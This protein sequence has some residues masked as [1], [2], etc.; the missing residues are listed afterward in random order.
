MFTNVRDGLDCDRVLQNRS[1]SY[2]CVFLAE[3]MS[4]VT[5]S[6]YAIKIGKLNGSNYRTWPFNMRLYLECLGL[7]EHADGTA[8]TPGDGASAEVWQNFARSAK[9][10]W[11]N[12]R[13]A[14]NQST[15]YMLEIRQPRRK[16]GTL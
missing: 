4:D 2:L 11:T 7:L 5:M 6:M 14:I 9:R 15:K 8:V 16:R 12:I 1:K 3:R 13:L 10:A